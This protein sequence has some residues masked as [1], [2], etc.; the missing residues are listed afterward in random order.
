MD[1]FDFEEL[2]ADMLD[3]TDEQ[4]EDQ[5][6]IE[7]KFYDKFDIDMEHGYALARSLLMHTPTVTTALMDRKYHAFVSKKEPVMLMRI[8]ATK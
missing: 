5:A 2:I 4:R 1:K 6:F 7:Q 8:E 3:V